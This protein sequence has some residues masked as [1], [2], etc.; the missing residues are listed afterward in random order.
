MKKLLFVLFALAILLTGCKKNNESSSIS[1]NTNPLIGLWSVAPEYSEY[2]HG[3][4]RF[5]YV[6]DFVNDNTAIEYVN[7]NDGS[8]DGWCEHSMPNHTGWYYERTKTCTYVFT[9]N[10]VIFTDG[11]IFTYMNNKLY[12]EGSSIFLSRW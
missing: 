12:E 3:Y 5:F 6:F 7:V 4:E 9:D 10:K 11:L 1:N 2:Y 8:W